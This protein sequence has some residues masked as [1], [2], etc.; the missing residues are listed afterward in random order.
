M[1]KIDIEWLSDEQECDT[2]GWNWAG[3]ARVKLDGELLLELIPRA[4]CFGSEHD[5]DAAQVHV[6]ILQAL[7]HEVRTRYGD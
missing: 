5:W 3:G 4:S 6:A 2:C 1:P 7:G